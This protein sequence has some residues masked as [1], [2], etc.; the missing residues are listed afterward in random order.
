MDLKQLVVPMEPSDFTEAISAGN[1]AIFISGSSDKYKSLFDVPAFWECARAS[2][3]DGASVPRASMTSYQIPIAFEEGAIRRALKSKNSV[4]VSHIDRVS[5]PLRQLCLDLE[6]ALG[7]PGSACVHCYI[8]PTGTGYD[9][10]HVD[11]GFAVTLQLAGSKKWEFNETPAIPWCTRVGGFREPGRL[12]WFGESD[13]HPNTDEVVPPQGKELVERTLQPGDLLV[14][15]PGTWHRVQ[16]VGGMSMSLNLKLTHTSSIDS[17]L[18]IL[19]HQ[20][21]GNELYR[22]PVPFAAEADLISGKAPEAAVQTIAE[23]LQGLSRA[24]AALAEDQTA[25]S[26]MWFRNF[27]GSQDNVA[28]DNAPAIASDDTLEI[29]TQISPRISVEPDGSTALLAQGKILHVWGAGVAPLL[30]KVLAHRRFMVMDVQKWPEARELGVD[31]THAILMRLMQAGLL[32]V[33][34]ADL[35]ANL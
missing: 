27:L 5:A 9:F 17:L 16:A 13:W 19:R 25:I 20:N 26:L 12:E 3:P 18:Q 34:S 7:F 8:S 1:R 28:A 6:A 10:F 33:T 30:R 4:C 15:P 24:F 22:K 14:M 23:Q 21:L 29:P 2:K 32:R 11:S 35:R 31:S